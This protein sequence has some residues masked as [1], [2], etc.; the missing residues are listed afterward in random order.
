[1]SHPNV[2]DASACKKDVSSS[3]LFTTLQQRPTTAYQTFEHAQKSQSN[4]RIMS[5]N[6][7]VRRGRSLAPDTTTIETKTIAADKELSKSADRRNPVDD[8]LTV[9]SVS[10]TQRFRGPR[11]DKERFAELYHMPKTKD[12]VFRILH[13]TLERADGRKYV[14]TMSEQRTD[15]VKIFCYKKPIAPG[16]WKYSKINNWRKTIRPLTI[17]KAPKKTYIDQIM[18]REK[19][20]PGPHTYHPKPQL[21]KSII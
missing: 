10:L 18:A 12:Q 8:A 1:M 20:S 15:L 7:F 11:N 3:A 16:S 5:A 13:G 9:K 6:A 21:R 19:K 4:G 14:R 17:A 2:V